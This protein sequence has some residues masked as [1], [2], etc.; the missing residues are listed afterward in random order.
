MGYILYG[1]RR[2]GSAMI[3]LALAE[4]G[5][6]AEI[7]PVPLEHDAQLA[8]EYRRHQPD[9]PGADPDPAGRH[10]G[11]RE[12]RH[13]A[14][15][16]GAAP[17]GRAAAAGRRSRPR[18]GAAL[19]DAGRQRALSLRHP[20]RLPGALRRRPRLHPRPGG[21]DGA[22]DLAA[23]RGRGAARAP[24][25]W[26]SGCSL[27]DLTSPCCPAGWATRPGCPGTARASRRWPAPSPPARPGRRPGRGISRGVRQGR[28]AG[29]PQRPAPPQFRRTNRESRH[30]PRPRP[31]ARRRAA[32]PHQP[33][34]GHP[35]PAERRR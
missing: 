17:G 18:H 22:G 26:A 29:L 32:H 6:E 23:D 5:A 15:A 25:C 8:A 35:D 2:S 24:S 27:A 10:G 20:Q 12:H 3:E 21:R 34:L 30:G 7:R 16:G 19:D 31:S 9:G 1:D 33:L 13:P 28:L 11:D 14:D 4:I